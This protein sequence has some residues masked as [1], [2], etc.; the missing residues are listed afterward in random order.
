V[1]QRFFIDV[2]GERDKASAEIENFL[3]VDADRAELVHGTGHVVFEIAI[4]WSGGKT[5]GAPRS[6]VKYLQLIRGV[7]F[8]T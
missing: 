4:V 2:V 1:C 5:Q 7:S 8:E 3:L 6:G